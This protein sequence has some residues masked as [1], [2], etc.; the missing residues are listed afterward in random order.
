MM[1][2]SLE[3]WRMLGTK[4][5]VA[6][7]RYDLADGTTDLSQDRQTIS[8]LPAPRLTVKRVQVAAVA[9]SMST[10]A[11]KRLDTCV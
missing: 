1:E 8:K 5:Q 6:G 11:A 7:V 4:I 10:N 2:L 9:L 3:S